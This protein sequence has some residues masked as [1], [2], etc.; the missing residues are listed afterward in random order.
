VTRGCAAS[1]ARCGSTASPRFPLLSAA[2]PLAE[3]LL[4]AALADLSLA[5]VEGGRMHAAVSA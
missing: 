1:R 4:P 3:L 2:A 5:H